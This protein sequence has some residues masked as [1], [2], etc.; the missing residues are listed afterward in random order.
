MIVGLI[1]VA[2]A[3]K[4]YRREQFIKE[5]F[6]PLDFKDELVKMCADLTGIRIQARAWETFK[7]IV[8][9]HD[10]TTATLPYEITGRQI[11]QRLAT[12]VMRKRYPG[13]FT[14]TWCKAA[15]PKLMCGR[16]IVCGDV[17]FLN[18]M[19]AIMRMAKR[20]NVKARF[21]FCDYRSDRHNATLDH[22]SEK[23]AQ[24]MLA[25]GYKDGDEVHYDGER[26]PHKESI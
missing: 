16:S 1:G 5:G 25:A 9:K 24:T 17:R 20:W 21:I 6:Y 3:G 13:H 19:Q 15:R 8:L 11:A 2:G 14:K 7:S 23:L 12:E 22:D 10:A 26:A 4:T 18:E